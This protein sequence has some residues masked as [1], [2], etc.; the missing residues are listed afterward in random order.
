MDIVRQLQ[1]ELDTAQSELAAAEIALI[2]ATA[3][4]GSA[5]EGADRLK[6]AVAALNGDTSPPSEAPT[7]GSD[8]DIITY[9]DRTEE[10][11]IKQPEDP[12]AHIPCA[13]CGDKG[14]MSEQYVT[15]PSGAAVRMLVCRNCGNQT[16]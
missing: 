13:G 15:A 6:A 10:P 8:E 2:E 12:L 16:F 7:R 4:A 11:P 3:R 5:R 14:S 9:L 1:E